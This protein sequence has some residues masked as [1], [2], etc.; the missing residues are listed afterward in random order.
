MRAPASRWR[1]STCRH[2]RLA[3]AGRPHPLPGAQQRRLRH[4]RAQRGRDHRLV[5]RAG[6]DGGG[7]A[8]GA[9]G[10]RA[11]AVM[12]PSS[13]P[14][15]GG[16]R[17]RSDGPRAPSGPR[18]SWAGWPHYLGSSRSPSRSRARAAGAIFSNGATVGLALVARIAVYS[19]LEP[20]LFPDRITGR[21]LP[22]IEIERRL[23]Y[24]LNYSSGLGS[25][26]A[27]ALPLLLA[28]TASAEDDLRAGSRGGRDARGGAH[29]LADHIRA[30]RSP[31]GRSAWRPSSSW[32]R[33]G[34][35]SS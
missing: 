6:R 16:R 1:G 34:S 35:R 15:R 5:D 3:A 25:L 26:A 12:S 31:P 20:S 7:R 4:R 23:A 33:T 32:L 22:G 14:S 30:S 18:S 21:F 29:P 17:S 9:G 24:P 28:A 8:A 11:G 10:T 2:R 27:I 13:R 19:R